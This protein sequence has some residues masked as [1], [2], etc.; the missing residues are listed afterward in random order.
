MFK[1]QCSFNSLSLSFLHCE[2]LMKI[3]LINVINNVFLWLYFVTA[4]EVFPD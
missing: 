1:L 2:D 4:T 3:F